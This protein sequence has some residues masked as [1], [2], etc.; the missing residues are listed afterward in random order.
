MIVAATGHRPDKLG[1]YSSEIEDRLF[2]GACRYIDTL[3]MRGSP[4]TEGISGVALGWDMAWA[5]AII[6]SGI[7]LTAAVPFLGQEKKW[8]PIQQNRYREI[9][10]RASR[11]HVV[12]HGGYANWKF[13]K[14]NEWMVDNCNIVVALWNGSPGGTANCVKYAEKL[15]VIVDNLWKPYAL[16]YLGN[17]SASETIDEAK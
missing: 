16:I 5:L 3:E 1:G 14:R 2:R 8:H 4:V 7:P 11:V 12:C 17:H 9:L 10:S 15:G 6:E 13:Q